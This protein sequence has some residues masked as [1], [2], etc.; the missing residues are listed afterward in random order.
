MSE[1]VS[2]YTAGRRLNLGNRIV[3]R[4]DP[5]PE[6]AGWKSLELYLRNG[7]VIRAIL[8]SV[9]DQAPAPPPPRAEAGAPD[10]PPN[11][12]V[13]KSGEVVPKP[14]GPENGAESGDGAAGGQPQR[15]RS[16]TAARRDGR[17]AEG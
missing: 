17:A 7:W 6:A 11:E 15:G 10:G 8:P 1:A 3:Q 16:K 4:G 5:V 14:N 9:E 13:S 2:A 12:L